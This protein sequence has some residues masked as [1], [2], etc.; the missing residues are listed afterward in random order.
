MNRR[1]DVVV[2]PDLP[3]PPIPG[4]EDAWALLLDI[5]GTL[6][7]FQSRP[8]DVRL[9][10]EMIAVLARLFVQLEGALAV[11]SGRTLAE[12][13]RLCAPLRLAAGALHGAQHRDAEGRV[14]LLRAPTAATDR[15]ARECHLAVR[16]WEGVHVENKEGVAYVLHYRANP[17]VADEVKQFATSIALATDG[18][19]ETQFG[20]CVA[21]LKP[22]GPTKGR[23]L[24]ELLA[25]PPFAGRRPVAVGD[26][27]TD[28]AAFAQAAS[29]GGFGVVVGARRPTH[30]NYALATPVHTLLWL[31]ALSHQL[32]ERKDA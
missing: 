28:E 23:S 9:P 1:P 22:A 10:G 32:G 3:A 5:D 14:R 4:P 31:Q 12:V 17:T 25:L 16:L 8:R 18:A 26:D 11:L 29:L 13:D 24:R 27:L 21:E 20:D 19:F 30:A 15:V 7:G 6:V 2:A